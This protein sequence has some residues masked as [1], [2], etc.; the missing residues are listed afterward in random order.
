MVFLQEPFNP[1]SPSRLQWAMDGECSLKKVLLTDTFFWNMS[2]MS[3][4]RDLRRLR[5]SEY[6]MNNE[7]CMILEVLTKAGWVCLATRCTDVPGRLM[8]HETNKT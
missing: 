2:S 3:N 1:R 6:P 7:P 8:N 5:E 4:T